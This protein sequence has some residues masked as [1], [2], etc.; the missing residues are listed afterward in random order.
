MADGARDSGWFGW[1]V[2]PG[3]NRTKNQVGRGFVSAASAI[4]ASAIF[5][6]AARPPVW[7]QT[8]FRGYNRGLIPGA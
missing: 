6:Q 5:V 1:G 3:A 4:F 7:L 8:V 2:W